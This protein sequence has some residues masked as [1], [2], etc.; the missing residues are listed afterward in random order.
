MGAFRI[1]KFGFQQ[2]SNISFDDLFNM[3]GGCIGLL[4]KNTYNESEDLLNALN[5]IK[6]EYHKK[7]EKC[8]LPDYECCCRDYDDDDNFD[9]Y[10]VMPCSSIKMY[11]NGN[12]AS[13]FDKFTNSNS[14]CQ[15]GYLE[16]IVLAQILGSACGHYHIREWGG[17]ELYFLCD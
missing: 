4:E 9:M 12:V 3:L 10:V 8:P 14:I 15:E 17:G 5:S 11:Y 2:I 1:S 6:F 13:A 16:I 7:G